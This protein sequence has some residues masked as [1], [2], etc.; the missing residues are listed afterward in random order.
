MEE[1]RKKKQSARARNFIF[2]NLR[3]KCF[4]Q[5]KNNREEGGGTT[6]WRGPVSCAGH[7]FVYT[8]WHFTFSAP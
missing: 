7:V 4:N 6:S 1:E 8:Q 5:N 3:N 2:I